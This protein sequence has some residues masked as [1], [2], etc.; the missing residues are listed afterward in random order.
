MQQY[1]YSHGFLF[2]GFLI[3]LETIQKIIAIICIYLMSDLPEGGEHLDQSLLERL[4]GTLDKVLEKVD[5]QSLKLQDLM[6]KIDFF[7]QTQN[8]HTIKIEQNERMVIEATQSTKAAHKRLDE[9]DGNIE[10]VK[11]IPVH[12][13]RLNKLEKVFYGSAATI[14]LTLLSIIAYLYERGA[15]N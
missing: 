6:T 2:H 15:T 14:F 3:Y 9:M 1:K 5:D 7:Q 13:D 8:S 4:N 10:E 12:E 11:R